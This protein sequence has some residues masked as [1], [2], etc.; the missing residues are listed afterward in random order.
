MRKQGAF[1]LVLLLIVAA[2]GPGCGGSEKKA[3]QTGAATTPAQ[4]TRTDDATTTETMQTTTT[5]GI[6]MMAGAGTEPVVGK[7]T[8]TDTALLT[9]VR[10]ARHEGYDRVVFQFKNT[11]PGYDVRYVHRPIT[12]DGS[13]KVVTVEG[14]YVVRIRME[15][16]LDADLTQESAPRTYKGPQRFTPG[17]PE[18]AELVRTGGFEG[19]LTWA[20]GLVDR[21]DFRVTTMQSPPRLVIDF[22]NH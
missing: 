12:E 21:V 5:G 13:G 4:T 11:L 2:A 19:V 16:A 1:V 7:A 6:D 22:R 18:V 9:D 14:G 15:S 3:A 10:A 17:T 8:G 20:A